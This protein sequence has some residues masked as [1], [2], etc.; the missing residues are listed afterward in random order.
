ME[1][2]RE[3]LENCS[4]RR[5]DAELITIAAVYTVFGKVLKMLQEILL[6]SFSI[7]Q[8][9]QLYVMKS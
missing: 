3:L 2:G 4:V 9:S 6:I 8:Q 1:T 7:S 5:P